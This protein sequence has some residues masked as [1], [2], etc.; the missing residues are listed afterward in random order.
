MCVCDKRERAAARYVTSSFPLSVLLLSLSLS[1]LRHT[2]AHVTPASTSTYTCMNTLINFPLHIGIAS[3]RHTHSLSSPPTCVCQLILACSPPPP[4]SLS[5]FSS[6]HHLHRILTHLQ[7]YSPYYHHSIAS[8]QA[9]KRT[10]CSTTYAR[11]LRVGLSLSAG[12]LAAPSPR[13]LSL[14]LVRGSCDPRSL[15]DTK[16]TRNSRVRIS[17]EILYSK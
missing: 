3:A 13:P 9:L 10:S 11:C 14:S 5:S 15:R 2:H 7:S 16:M 6:P 1:L 8:H 4:P 17:R 12:L